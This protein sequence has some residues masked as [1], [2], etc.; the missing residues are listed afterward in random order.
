MS[1]DHARIYVDIWSDDD[2]R[3]LPSLGQWLYFQ[4]YSSPSLSLCGVADWRPARIAGMSADL[5][6]DDVEYAAGWL[7][8]GEFVII[9]RNTEEALI[10]SWVKHDGLMRSPNM[11]KAFVKAHAS[12]GSQVLRGVVVSQLATLR[13]KQPDL[14]GWKHAARVLEGH[15]ISVDEAFGILPRNPSTNPSVKGSG[16]PFE[17]DPTLRSPFSKLLTPYSELPSKSKTSLVTSPELADLDL[18]EAKF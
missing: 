13:E 8:E 3:A 18:E 7:E 15:P 10:R 12:V 4:L 17:N 5:T 1:R 11:V 2:W 16:N 14:A 6:A 9:D